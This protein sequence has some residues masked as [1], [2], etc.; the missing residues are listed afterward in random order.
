MSRF[1]DLAQENLRQRNDLAR[2]SR[3]VRQTAEGD[4]VIEYPR[5]LLLRAPA[6]HYFAV[7]VDDAGV[8]STVDM[9]TSL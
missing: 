9:G 7:V 2:T 1:D 3:D 5:R 8:L 4:V 6:G